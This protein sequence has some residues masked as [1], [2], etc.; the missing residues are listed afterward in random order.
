MF[1]LK[2][3]PHLRTDPF[4]QRKSNAH[5]YKPRK[6]LRYPLRFFSSSLPACYQ[7]AA[8]PY[9]LGRT[10]ADIGRSATSLMDELQGPLLRDL[11]SRDVGLGLSW[12]PSKPTE[13]GLVSFVNC[14]LS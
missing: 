1:S 12:R 13:V 9:Q 10:F 2:I 11:R 4:L 5:K 14:L 7:R 3:L 6:F 8:G